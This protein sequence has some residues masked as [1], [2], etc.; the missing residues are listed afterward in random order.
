MPRLGLKKLRERMAAFDVRHTQGPYVAHPLV[1]KLPLNRPQQRR[2][3]LAIA[4]GNW[5]ASRCRVAS[6]KL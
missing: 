6:R 1:S 2:I 5:L 4:H 3:S